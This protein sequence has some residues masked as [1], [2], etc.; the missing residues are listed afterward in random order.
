MLG[1][2]TRGFYY[3]FDLLDRGGHPSFSKVMSFL[4]ISTMLGGELL[5][6]Y[7]ESLRTDGLSNG[8]LLYTLILCAM[9]FGMNGL[10]SILAA[11]FGGLAEAQAKAEEQ[12]ANVIKA[13][14]EEIIA[15]RAAGAE[16]NTE[17]T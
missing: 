1:K 7:H 11:R 9:P 3:H 5:F 6:G 4:V 17:P 16:D 10:K 12:R 2:R 14:S 8:F 13:K 15:R